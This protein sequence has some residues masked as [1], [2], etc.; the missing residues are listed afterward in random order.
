VSRRFRVDG[1]PTSEHQIAVVVVTH[2]SVEQVGETL[3]AVTEQLLAG[4]ELV[5]VDNASRDA[6]SAAV[7][8]AIPSAQLLE[9]QENLGFAGGC[10]VGAAASSAPL[11]LFLN[12]D[13]R[14]APGFLDA[15]RRVA[16]ERPGWGAW[17]ALVTMNG[18]AEINTSGNVVHFLGVGWAG[19]CGEPLSAA[20]TEPAE[21]SFASGAALAVRREAWDEVGG[22]DERYFMYGEDLDLS[23][24]LRLAGW[25]VGVAPGAL[26]EHD[27]EFG[28][29]ERKWFLLERNRWWTVLTDYPG[30]LLALLLPALLAAELALVAIAAQGG[31]LSSKLRA[32]AAVLGEL[33]E[34]LARRRRVQRGRVVSTSAFAGHLSASLDSPYLG[35]GARLAP[36]VFLQCSYWRIVVA[37]LDRRS[38]SG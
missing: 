17:Q 25:G 7:R 4:D 31:W 18:G 20:P 6:T 28:K 24:R 37:V 38:P 8:E 23:L 36:V 11:L 5:V 14:P 26:V 35:A 10:N 9:Q 2:E 27:Y 30:A 16:V 32:Q 33:P 22:F 19:R 3:R 1:V 29:G 12:P 34:I 21:V 15:L 13:A